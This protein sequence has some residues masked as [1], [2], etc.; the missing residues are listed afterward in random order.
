[1]EV[2]MPALL[3]IEPHISAVMLIVRADPQNFCSEVVVW[4]QQRG[5]PWKCPFWGQQVFLGEP[6]FPDFTFAPRTPNS[7]PQTKVRGGWGGT[8][9]AELARTRRRSGA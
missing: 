5:N 6:R 7:Q 8:V 2:V 9:N 3:W 1:M 4:G